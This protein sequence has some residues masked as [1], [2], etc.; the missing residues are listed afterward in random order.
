MVHTDTNYVHTIQLCERCGREI[1]EVWT[2]SIMTSNDYCSCPLEEG[3][4]EEGNQV[5]WI[6]P[7]CD[8]GVNPTSIN[9]DCE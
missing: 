4:L 3:N 7:K 8:R 5:G 2:S 1:Q 6:C 9:C